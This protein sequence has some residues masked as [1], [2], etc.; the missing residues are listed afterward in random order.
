M[1][2]PTSGHVIVAY[3]RLFCPAQTALLLLALAMI[4]GTGRCAWGVIAS[5]GTV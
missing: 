3:G 2:I 5:S 1:S 4:S